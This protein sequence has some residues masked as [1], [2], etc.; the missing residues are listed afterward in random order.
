MAINPT[1]N[2]W[3]QTEGNYTYTLYVYNAAGCVDSTSQDLYVEFI[4]A[5]YI[6]NAMYP[7]HGSF[8]VANF[9]PKGTGMSEF[10]IEIFDTF[11]NII[12]ESKSLDDEGNQLVIGM[13]NL[14][15]FQLNKMYIYGK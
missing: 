11:G 9:I 15:V 6:P 3:Y 7:G 8:E 10:H 12:W 14:M 2:Y 4:K 13:E 5:L 1:Y